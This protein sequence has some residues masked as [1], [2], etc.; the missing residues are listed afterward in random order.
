MKTVIVELKNTLGNSHIVAVIVN[1][2]DDNEAITF[3]RTNAFATVADAKGV[4]A[5]TD[6][7]IADQCLIAL[8]SKA[9]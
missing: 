8:N 3:A 2:L 4:W 9:E 1:Q 6:A 5:I 7:Y